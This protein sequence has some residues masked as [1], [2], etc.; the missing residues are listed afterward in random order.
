MSAFNQLQNKFQEI[1]NVLEQDDA[2]SQM[3]LD[4]INH[5]STQ[6]NHPKTP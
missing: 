1:M 2:L 4:M 3:I 6:V 5:N